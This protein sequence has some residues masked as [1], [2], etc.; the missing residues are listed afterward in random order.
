M[1]SQPHVIVLGLGVV[2]SSIAEALAARKYRVTALEQFA[3][4]H[5]RGSSH[6]DSRIFRRVPHEGPAYVKLAARSYEVWQ[7][8]NEAAGDELL[9]ACGGVDAGP[10]DSAMVEAALQ[11]CQ[12]MGRPFGLLSGDGLN[13]RFPQYNLPAHW[14][15]VFQPESGYVRPDATLTFLHKAAREHGARLMFETRVTEI[16]PQSS[17]IIVRAGNEALQGDFLVIAAGA[18]LP[19]IMPPVSTM[20]RAERRVTAW[21]RPQGE[22][23][24]ASR[25]AVFVIDADGGW[26]GM[27]TPRGD[28][29]IGHDKHLGEAID[30]DQPPQL[31][32]E[33]DRRK[34]SDCMSR[35]F[36]GFSETPASMKACLY[37]IASDHHF[38]IDRHADYAHVLVFSCC[39]GHGFKYAPVYGEIAA[40]LIVDRPRDDL[41]GF[42]LNRP[43]QQAVTRFSE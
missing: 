28:V 16:E 32:N 18:W 9:V 33:E 19:K 22:S 14:R 34:L 31:P 24:D 11:L 17:G 7:R 42:R 2:G 29:K 21:Y 4:L 35:Y 38:V 39:S 36:R 23:L 20:L 13:R 41:A 12:Q 3:P 30:P 40:D 37:T 1:S 5:E 10:P 43:I 6:G 27:P 25:F 26:Y 8:W 15:A